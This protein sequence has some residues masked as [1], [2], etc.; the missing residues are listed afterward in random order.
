MIF[1]KYVVVILY[2]ISVCSGSN[3]VKAV[4]SSF[5]IGLILPSVTET[6][7][8][9]YQSNFLSVD[10]LEEGLYALKITI[11]CFKISYLPPSAGH[12]PMELH[13]LLIIS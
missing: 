5:Q 6:Q 8:K 3:R 7:P 2:S 4:V 1:V 10:M 13:I 9:M 11:V 12:G